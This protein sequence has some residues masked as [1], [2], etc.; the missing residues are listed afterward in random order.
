MLDTG[1][2]N[3]W[4][5]HEWT[6]VVLFSVFFGF[7]QHRCI[8]QMWICSFF[9]VLLDSHYNP[10]PGY[11]GLIL[12]TLFFSMDKETWQWV[13]LSGY[14]DLP[15]PRDFSAGASVGNGKLVMWVSYSTC[16]FC[17]YWA[18][19]LWAFFL[20]K[21]GSCCCL[22][23]VPKRLSETM[24]IWRLGWRKVVIR[25]LCAWYKYVSGRLQEGSCV[26]K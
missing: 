26:H 19:V 8:M 11:L 16:I 5:L 9:L 6:V 12:L 25:H 15:P 21:V 4:L 17:F 18:R 23:C 3:G 13:E 14:G 7:H 2:L 20:R 22:P 24:Q 1:E 10:S